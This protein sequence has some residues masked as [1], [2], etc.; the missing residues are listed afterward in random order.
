MRGV[1]VSSPNIIKP[2]AWG[3]THWVYTPNW[4]NLT[5]GV[6]AGLWGVL[7]YCGK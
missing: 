2:I 4:N 1:Y 7:K 3:Y 5:R 6:G